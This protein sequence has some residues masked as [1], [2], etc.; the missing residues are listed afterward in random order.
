METRVPSAVVIWLKQMGYRREA[1]A[2]S[3]G[4]CPRYLAVCGVVCPS[5]RLKAVRALS[6][7]LV[8]PQYVAFPA[9]ANSKPY[10]MPT[11][12]FSLW[13][14]FSLVSKLSTFKLSNRT[15]RDTSR[16]A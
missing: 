11:V 3:F 16:L 10:C 6:Q 12:I 14:P 7:M 4:A 5:S 8:T 15:Q 9:T 1:G 13:L 2:S